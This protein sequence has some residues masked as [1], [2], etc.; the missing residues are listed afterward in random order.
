V[1]ETAVDKNT[2]TV[3]RQ[4]DVGFAWQIVPVEPKPVAHGMQ[5]PSHNK[6]GLGVFAANAAH[7]L[8]ALMRAQSIGHAGSR[9]FG[10]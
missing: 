7:E 2:H 5:Q 10:F 3:S 8:A 6:L 1:P 4:N 9:C